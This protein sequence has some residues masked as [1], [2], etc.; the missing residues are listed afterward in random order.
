MSH[1]LSP[2]GF[3]G[4][5]NAKSSSPCIK[6]A[7]QN[8]IKL[9]AD[10]VAIFY[11]SKKYQAKLVQ[12]YGKKVEQRNDDI[13]IP[14]INIL[15][16]DNKTSK[17]FIVCCAHLKSTK[18]LKGESIRLRQLQHLLP[19]VQKLST[20]DSN[21]GIPVFMG[22][23][24]NTNNNESYSTVYN[25]IMFP[26]KL[27]KNKNDKNFPPIPKDYIKGYNHLNLFSAY[28]EAEVP[29]TEKTKQSEPMYTTYKKRSGGV[30]KHC[31]DYIF[32]TKDKAKVTR[33]LSI[34]SSNTINQKTLLPGFEYPSDHIA[35]QA[36]FQF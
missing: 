34:P 26:S 24:L 11:N 4:E 5:F 25:S 19:K 35:I 15:F 2:K 29:N 3:K 30:M 20:S 9:N 18:N 14:A 21:E 17:D 33:L 8:N 6:I 1:Y 27:D 23:D 7:K 16:T 10:G 32:Y 13:D 12:K 22:C 36:C 28:Y 31:I